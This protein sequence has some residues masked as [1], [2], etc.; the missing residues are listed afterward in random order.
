MTATIAVTNVSNARRLIPSLL[1]ISRSFRTT[2]HESEN[3]YGSRLGLH[4]RL[5]LAGLLLYIKTSRTA[6]S[7]RKRTYASSLSD[8]MAISL[9]TGLRGLSRNPWCGKVC[10]ANSHSF[11]AAIG[12]WYNPRQC[13]CQRYDLK[14]TPLDSGVWI[15]VSP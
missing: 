1:T 14:F 10:T 9:N 15:G 12:V 8:L 11:Y 3:K 4:F 2:N 7:F 5:S 6:S 13:F